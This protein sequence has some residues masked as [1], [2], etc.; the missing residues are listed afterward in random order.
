VTKTF[1]DG[2]SEKYGYD[3]SSRLASVTTRTKD[4]ALY[5]LDGEG[6]RSAYVFTAFNGDP[7]KA[8]SD[9]YPLNGLDQV[10]ADN[11]TVG[12]A[13]TSTTYAYD[14]NGNRTTATFQTTQITTYTWNDDDRLVGIQFPSGTTNAYTYDANGI[15]TSK[16]DSTGNVRHLIDPKTQSILATYDAVTKARLTTY[17]Q[18]PAQ[19]DEIVSYKDSGGTKHYPHADM[20]GSV[21]GS[22]I[23]QGL[24]RR[25]G[26]TTSM[27]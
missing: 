19:I 7:S 5:T 6:N 25:H 2:T 18:N 4:T 12:G 15:R 1:A 13:P 11:R 10:T 24:P 16:N 8:I 20:L 9:G 22:A 17:N 14:N 21:H 26:C 3:T 23:R 27:G